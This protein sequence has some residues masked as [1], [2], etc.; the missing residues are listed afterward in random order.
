VDVAI[1]GGG[2]VGITTARLL[3]DEGMSVAVVEARSV[4]GEVTGKSTAKITSQ[5]SIIYKKIESKFGEGGARAYAE[6]NE[7][8][9]RRILTLA[10]EY[11]IDCHIETKAA[12]TYTND[13]QHVSDIEQEVEVA[14]RLGLPA[15]VTRDTGLPLGVLAAMRRRKNMWQASPRP[16]RARAT[17]SSRIAG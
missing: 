6:A 16:F 1:V 15:S 12:Y 11:A 13:P 3:K 14:Q 4:G 8:G 5:H 17:T 10:S 2:K 7:A 9:L